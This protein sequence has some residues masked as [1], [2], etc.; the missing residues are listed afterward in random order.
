MLRPGQTGPGRLVLTLFSF[1]QEASP[2]QESSH[3][4]DRTMTQGFPVIRQSDEEKLGVFAKV[5]HKG[6]VNETTK[7]RMDEEMADLQRGLGAHR[8][9]RGQR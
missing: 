5:W 8:V 3:R 2:Q 7:K 4:A 6:R 1:K 9:A